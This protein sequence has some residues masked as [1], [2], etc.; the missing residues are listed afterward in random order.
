MSF[1]EAL[2]A[3]PQGAPARTL[4]FYQWLRRDW[5]S[6]FAELRDS[7]PIL[8]LPPFTLVT[9]WADVV[10]VLS[11]PGT[12][13]VP[14]GPHM[15]PSVGPFMLGHDESEPNWRDK[16]VMRA[17]MR[18]DDVPAIRALAAE[19][20]SAALAAVPP[21]TIDVVQTVS[22]LVPLRVVQRCFGFPGPDDASMLRWSWATQADM[23]HNLT[24]DPRLVQACIAA[25]TEMR[26]WVRQFLA[27]R[28][29]WRDAAGEDTVS[30]LLR[31]SGAGLSGLD[32]EQVVSNICG[33]LVG[34]I[35]TTSQ[36]IVNATEQILLRPDV[37]ARAIAAARTADAAFDAPAFDAI[38]WEALRFNPMT[39]FVAR[40]AAEAALLGPGSR[41]ETTVHAGA[42]VAVGIGS[43]MFD[44]G[45]FPDPDD[46]RERRRT[47]YLHTGFGPHECLGQFVAYAIIPETIRQILR[48]PAIRL[49]GGDQSHVDTAG[50]PFAE[51][52]LLGH[53]EADHG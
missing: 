13:R 51:H 6:L 36:A 7:R 47:A 33:L 39:T 1:L 8:P 27:G 35:E 25:G 9:R 2:D 12:F 37:A 17:L 52:F 31:M 48:M 11:R 42:V 10:D 5:R 43:A 30:R 16:S 28:Q 22:R 34:A 38:V 41:H 45:V 18:W 21:P 4:L 23:F 3:I 19:T 44:P 50:G 53:G 40:V 20:A 26:A 49:L 46:F 24:N 15:D 29:P 32:A 14:Y